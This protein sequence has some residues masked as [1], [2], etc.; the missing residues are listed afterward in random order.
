M[1]EWVSFIQI[2]FICVKTIQPTTTSVKAKESK[3]WNI[4]K[5]VMVDRWFQIP[6]NWYAALESLMLESGH[7]HWDFEQTRKASRT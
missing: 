3:N 4:N 2:Y 6:K 5:I 7:L 1:N